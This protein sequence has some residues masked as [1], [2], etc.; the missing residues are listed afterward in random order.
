M[1]GKWVIYDVEESGTRDRYH[2]AVVFSYKA[3]FA[4]EIVVYLGVITIYAVLAMISCALLA[5]YFTRPIAELRAA[6]GRLAAGDLEARVG[7][8]MAKRGDE[9]GDLVRDFNAM[10]LED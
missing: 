2:F 5:L 8:G 7:G 6:T 4:R 10:V 9:I 1:I 3:L